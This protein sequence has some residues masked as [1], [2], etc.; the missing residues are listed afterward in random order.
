MNKERLV[1]VQLT[2]GNECICNPTVL[3]G[4][5][6][7]LWDIQNEKVPAGTLF[8]LNAAWELFLSRNK[9]LNVS[10]SIVEHHQHEVIDGVVYEEGDVTYTL[11][12]NDG[13]PTEATFTLRQNTNPIQHMATQDGKLYLYYSKVRVIEDS[14]EGNPIY[15]V[16]DEDGNIVIDQETGKPLIYDYV[17]ISIIEIFDNDETKKLFPW[18]ADE[19]NVVKLRPTL[20]DSELG[21]L[22]IT[23]ES[24][25]FLVDNTT[26]ELTSVQSVYDQLQ[27][28]LGFKQNLENGKAH[29]STLSDNLHEDFAHRSSVVDAVNETLERTE[30]NLQSISGLNEILYFADQ[31][32]NNAFTD[33]DVPNLLDAINWVQDHEIGNVSSTE[34]ETIADGLQ[35]ISNKLKSLDLHVLSG[36]E[37]DGEIYNPNPH[38]VQAN[39]LQVIVNDPND[40]DNTRIDPEFY[41]EYN[42]DEAIQK[43]FDRINVEEDTFGKLAN[44]IGTAEDIQQLDLLDE[45][46]DGNPTLISLAIENKSR[47][48]YILPIPNDVIDSIII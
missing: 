24:E 48:D 47:I 32:R 17:S 38:N 29:G 18:Y 28:D 7:G 43:L 21:K 2:N 6:Q 30:K 22:E 40:E 41:K 23:P 35:I 8:D 37:V 4:T 13:N 34:Y 26:Q 42:V 5:H 46:V 27:K 14:D 12:D 9:F 25:V 3:L 31:I 44:A 33:S 20:N 11:K 36:H 1:G 45:V 19:N 39:Q 15:Y 16:K 10:F